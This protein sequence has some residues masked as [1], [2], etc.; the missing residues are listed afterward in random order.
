[1]TISYPTPEAYTAGIRAT[2]NAAADQFDQVPL[3]FWDLCGR[4]L[5]DFAGVASGHRVLD[6]CCGTGAAS[7]PA[8]ERTGPSGEVVAIDLADRLL[9]LGRSKAERRGLRN[10]DFRV[11]DLTNLDV[12]DRAF[13][14]VLCSFGVFFAPN[15][16]QAMLELARAVRPHGGLSLTTFGPRSF[17]PATTFF[18]E[19]VTAERPDMRRPQAP[20]ETRTP[21]GLARLCAGAGL[22][23]PDVQTE[24]LTMPVTPAEFW[25]MVEG[26]FLRAPLDKMGTA[27]SERV[28]RHF[29]AR[30]EYEG[31]RE[32]VSD[33]LYTRARKP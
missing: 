27:G 19:T 7:L 4:K 17:E 1:M 33:I 3:S 12:P 18:T 26:S 13:D 6:V 21:D 22:L 10:V 15:L 20:Q 11:G 23:V 9:D 5:V 16:V 32:V 14:V 25:I 29:M 24:V 2:F 28:R 30:M 31:V 8:A